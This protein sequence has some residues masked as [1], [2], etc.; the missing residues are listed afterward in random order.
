MDTL[1]H[2]HRFLS[3]R[4]SESSTPLRLFTEE[5]GQL[6]LTIPVTDT[7]D[8]GRKGCVLFPDPSFGRE[9]PFGPLSLCVL[10]DLWGTWG[11]RSTG[12]FKGQGSRL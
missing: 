9:G 7:D 5:S 8:V 6:G 3:G 4:Y 2:I 1:F 12:N 10:R 11:F